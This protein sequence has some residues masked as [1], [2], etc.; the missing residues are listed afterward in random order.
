MARRDTGMHSNAPRAD[1]YFGVTADGL[2][3][4]VL[5]ADLEVEEYD[6]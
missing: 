3:P 5:T 1:E 2:M 6:D 4:E